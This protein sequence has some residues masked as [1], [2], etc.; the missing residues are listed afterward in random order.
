[1]CSC[2]FALIAD[3]YKGPALFIF[4]DLRCKTLVSGCLHDVE[5]IHFT[6]AKV[7]FCLI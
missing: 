3:D 5:A 6:V 1:M 7:K 2:L 4:G